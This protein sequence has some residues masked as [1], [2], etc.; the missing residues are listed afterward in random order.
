LI[1][2]P[3]TDAVTDQTMENLRIRKIEMGDA[4]AIRRIQGE[5][6]KSPVK[7]DFGRIIRDQEQRGEDAS[8]VAEMDGKIVGY[9]ISYTVN[10]GF[11]L[12]KS[13]WIAT[14]GVAPKFMGQGI[15][16]QLAEA[17][18]QAYRRMGVRHILTSVRWD[19]VDLLSFFKTLGFDRSEFINLSK[20]LGP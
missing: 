20:E 17:V 11:G 14:L 1:K 19:S 8:F 15:G 12:D 4:E 16:R 2:A 18:F 9:M 13:A 3:Q 5:I 6:T 7:I 10:A